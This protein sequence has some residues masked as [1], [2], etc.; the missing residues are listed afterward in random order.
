MIIEVNGQFEAA[1]R[2]GGEQIGWKDRLKERY[3]RLVL[4]FVLRRADGVRLLYREQ[5]RAFFAAPLDNAVSFADFVP[6]RR[7][8]EGS[9]S[10]S[11]YILFIGYPWYLKGV[12]LLIQ[13]FNL[14]AEEFPHWSLR[15][16]G[17]CPDKAPF[18][19]LARGNPRIV[20]SDPVKYEEVIELTAGCSIFVLPS[21][22]EAMGRVLLEAMASRKPVVASN[23][24]GIPTIVK[25]GETGLLFE[26]GNV[27]DLAAKLKT[28]MADAGYGRQLADRGFDFVHAGFMEDHYLE[29]FSSLVQQVSSGFGRRS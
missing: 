18:V 9:G 7:F 24:D 1:F 11:N 19:E 27:S 8:R 13:A 14:L 28:I 17:Y 25:H 10:P 2:F 26:S 20:L 21:R 3:V 6:I 5:L 23:V 22:T 12:D 29:R 16:V 4:P 15:I